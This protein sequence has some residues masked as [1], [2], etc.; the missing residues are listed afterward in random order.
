MKYFEIILP[1]A[2]NKG[3]LVPQRHKLFQDYALT[4]AGGLTI[5]GGEHAGLWSDER[6]GRIYRDALAIY[7]VATTD[8]IFAQIVAEAFRLFSDQ[9]AIFHAEIGT[10]TI[11]SRPPAIAA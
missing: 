11:A 8:E 3:R 6:T 5:V 1:L 9:E 4:N 7:R 10:A 2:D